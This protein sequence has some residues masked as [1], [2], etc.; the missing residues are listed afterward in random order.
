[1]SLTFIFSF[2]ACVKRSRHN[3]L[4]S[5][6]GKEA[7]IA[8]QT[9]QTQADVQQ[10]TTSPQINQRININTASAR[11]LETLPGI[12]KA[13]AA[14]IIEHREKYGPFR[15]SEHLIMVR[16]ISDTRFRGLRDLITIE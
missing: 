13:L 7:A 16:G 3:I 2:C 4:S 5:R 8:T 15:R 6:S 9:S 14:R 12:G 11:E 10:P 1:L